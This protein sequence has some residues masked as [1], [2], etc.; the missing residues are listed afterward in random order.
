MGAIVER[1]RKHGSTAVMAQILIIR[2]KKIVH[3]EAKTFGRRPAAA[4]WIEKRETELLKPDCAPWREPNKEGAAFKRCNRS[5]HGRQPQKYRAHEGACA[6]DGEDA[7]YRRSAMRQHSLAKY[8]RICTDLGYKL[9]AANSCELSLQRKSRQS[10][11]RTH[12]AEAALRLAIQPRRSS[13]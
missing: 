5:I 10:V 6:Q 4:S 13:R 11:Q 3:R 7:R 1:W 12:H 8:C 9:Q 2:D